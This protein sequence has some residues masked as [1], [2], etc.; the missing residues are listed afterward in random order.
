MLLSTLP[1]RAA[2]RLAS[3]AMSTGGTPNNGLDLL[4]QNAATVQENDSVVRLLDLGVKDGKFVEIA[5]AGSV[6]ADRATAVH[7]AKGL[8]AFPGVVDAHTHIAGIYQDIELDM[9][10]ESKCA[11][12]GGVTTV[13][14]Y[15]RSGQCYLWEGGAYKDLYQKFLDHATDNYHCDYAYHVSPIEGQHI[16]EL[17]WLI[18]D[19]GVVS[20]G[21]VF[22]F[23]GQHGLHGARTKERQQDFLMLEADDDRYDLGHYDF[24]LRELGRLA[25]KHP[26]L[27]EFI[28]IG[29]HCE[30][31]ELLAKWTKLVQG[32]GDQGHKAWS[33]ARPTHS[34]GLAIWTAAYLS[35]KAKVPNVNILHITC[36]DAMEAALNVEKIFPDVSFGREVTAGHLLLDY[37]SLDD[38]EPCWMKVNPPIRSREDVETLWEH[39]AQGH[40]DWIVTDHA[41]APTDF[42][43]NA[44]DPTNI[45][46]AKAGFGGVEYLLAGIYSEG[47]VN[48]GVLTP[49]DVARML[50]SN[51]AKRFGLGKS[52]GSIAVGYD[53]DVAL[54][55]PNKKWTIDAND[56]FSTQTYTPFQGI[57]V[58]GQV[59]STFLRGKKVFDNGDVVGAPSGKNLVRPM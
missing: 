54:F 31:P 16:G 9:F 13:M 59:Q 52:K 43:V 6:Q 14:P 24:V 44:E 55:D 41:S 2:S 18:K 49:Q 7:D 4:I 5:K 58:T 30:T 51:P 42:K 26:E 46:D 17:E 29:F 11:A 50:C 37:H 36:A 35:A 20:L 53:A 57:D 25:E 8:M 33:D 23:Y 45:W 21:E 1:L 34:E 48:R 27:K 3:R 10:Q 22:M 56:S 28:Q 32:R 39:V 47:V 12:Q 38:K 19:Q 40:V 15:I